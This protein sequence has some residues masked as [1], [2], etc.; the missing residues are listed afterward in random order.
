M[1]SYLH[2]KNGLSNSTEIVCPFVSRPILYIFSQN[3]HKKDRFSV[4]FSDSMVKKYNGAQSDFWFKNIELCG[5]QL[6]IVKLFDLMMSK[7]FFHIFL[8]LSR[9]LIWSCSSKYVDFVCLSHGKLL[10]VFVKQKMRNG[11]SACT[12]W[13]ILIDRPKILHQKYPELVSGTLNMVILQCESLTYRYMHFKL[14]F[15]VHW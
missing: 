8:I 11:G 15:K 6:N 3:S 1:L 13:C 7:A 14:Q 12:A 2:R 10:H 4:A 5:S 9:S